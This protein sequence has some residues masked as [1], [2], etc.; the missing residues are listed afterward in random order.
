[1]TTEKVNDL[2]IVRLGDYLT[3]KTFRIIPADLSYIKGGISEVPVILNIHPEFCKTLNFDIRKLQKLYAFSIMG[4][5]LTELNDGPY[6][7]ETYGGKLK[8]LELNDCGDLWI[9]KIEWLDDTKKLYAVKAEEVT[10][11]LNYCRKPVIIN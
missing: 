2:E 7:S 9:L 10:E 5:K 11:L 3:S 8:S 6:Y 4:K 1:M